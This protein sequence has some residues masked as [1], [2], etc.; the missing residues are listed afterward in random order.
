M[1]LASA[2]DANP[3][4]KSKWGD[5]GLYKLRY[6]YKRR[7][8]SNNSREFCKVME[9]LGNQEVVFRYEDIALG[10]AGSMSERGENKQLSPKGKSKYDI[11]LYKGGAYCHHYWARRIYF[12]KRD[13]GRFLPKSKTDSMENDKRVANVPYVPQKGEEAIAP[14]NTP[15]KGRLNFKALLSAKLKD[16]KHGRK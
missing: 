10:Q 16:W 4:D 2:D 8:A 1:Q 9:K 11:F 15:N 5:A 7:K 6:V 12:R 13:K 3:T 14:I